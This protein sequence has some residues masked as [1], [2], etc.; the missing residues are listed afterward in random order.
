MVL[1]LTPSVR[2]RVEDLRQ[3]VAEARGEPCDLTFLFRMSLA[4]LDELERREREGWRIIVERGDESEHL[5]LF[6]D[7]DAEDD[8]GPVRTRWDQLNEGWLDDA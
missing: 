4:A 2:A 7:D 6:R 5:I 8:D 1:S 3:R